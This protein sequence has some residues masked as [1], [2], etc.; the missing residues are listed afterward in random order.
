MG[1]DGTRQSVNIDKIDPLYSILSKKV[2]LDNDKKEEIIKGS[3][4]LTTLKIIDEES[5]EEATLI[6]GTKY[7]WVKKDEEG[8]IIIYSP[9]FE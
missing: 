1:N 3:K 5:K 4:L 7:I 6:N 9:I 2:S 8:K